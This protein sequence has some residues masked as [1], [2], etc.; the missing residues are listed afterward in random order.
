M[1]SGSRH[2]NAELVLK[3]ALMMQATREGVSLGDIQEKLE[4]SRRTAERMRDAV[5][6]VF[7]QMEVVASGEKIK[8]WR[9]PQ[10]VLSSLVDG[11]KELLAD[12]NT[13]IEL[14]KR[15]NMAGQAMQLENLRLSLCGAMRPEALRRME[16]DLE[17]LTMA[18][19]LALRP[20]PKIIL[21]DETI[22]TIRSA[23]LNTHVL[24]IKYQGRV[25][26]KNSWQTLHPYGLLY[27]RKSY[28]VAHN[29]EMNDWRLWL[30][31]NMLEITETKDSYTR[32]PNFSL[33]TFAERSFGVFQEEPMNIVLKFSPDAAKDAS[34][35]LFH[36]TQTVEKQT[37]NSLIV[38]F[39]TGGLTEICWHLFT[40]G[41]AVEILEPPA[42]RDHMQQMCKDSLALF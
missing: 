21:R 37:D 14:L 16:P 28:L 42:L 25:S 26:G 33:Q 29:P 20:G 4:V 34:T 27:G 2:E 8:R 30:L 7:P 36:P 5:E 35:Y 1:G 22:S 32:D 12:L 15:E 39:T 40:W 3:L 13:A 38:R 19:G 6:R 31:S 10:G 41:S 9:I 11:S 18:E 24:R 23:I 17:M